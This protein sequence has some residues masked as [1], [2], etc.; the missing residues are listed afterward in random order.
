MKKFAVIGSPISHSKSAVLHEAGF[1]E[2]SIEAEFNTVEV[3]PDDLAS[4][5]SLNMIDYV[6]V[7]VTLPHKEKMVDLVHKL[8]PAAK[9]IGA[10][11]T[12]FWEHEVLHGTN[13]DCVGV[14]RALQT[15]VPDLEKQNV[16]LLGAGG[17]ARA[18]LFALQ[19]AGAKT[20]IWNRSPDRAVTLAEEFHAEAVEAL[21]TLHP[22]KFDII[23]NSTSVGLK[24]WQSLI[25]PDFW[26]PQHVAF[27]MV[28]DPLE[29]RFLSEAAEAGARTITGDQMLV[30][31]A[32]EQFHLWHDMELEPEVMGNAFFLAEA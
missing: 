25:P 20:T 18:A 6:G 31:Q 13:T 27:D 32:L 5:I 10:V 11:N 26:T 22:E 24:A 12:L 1:N 30:H 7:A 23:I 4:W 9:I 29:T 16:L 2:L 8:S 14:L 28:Y 17:A 21:P 19:T 3:K 15:E